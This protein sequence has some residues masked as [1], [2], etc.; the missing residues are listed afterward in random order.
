MRTGRAFGLRSRLRHQLCRRRRSEMDM[1][2]TLVLA[3]VPMQTAQ[4]HEL[5]ATRVTATFPDGSY[6][7]EI[8]TDASALAAKLERK[9]ETRDV[10]RLKQI[11]AGHEGLFRKRLRV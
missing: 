5:G 3:L 4:A 7:I 10:E 11:L 1:L 9:P 8:A 6:Q 2:L